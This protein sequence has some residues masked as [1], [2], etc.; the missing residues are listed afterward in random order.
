M[1]CVTVVIGN[2]EDEG[3]SSYVELNCSAHGK[4]LFFL[5]DVCCVR[6]EVDLYR[7]GDQSSMMAKDSAKSLLSL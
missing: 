6:C 7:A 2:S 1:I 4:C 5:A 3:V